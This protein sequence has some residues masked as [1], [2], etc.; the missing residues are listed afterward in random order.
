[1]ADERTGFTSLT[2][3]R[4]GPPDADAALADIRRIYFRTTKQTIQHDLAHAID[5]LKSLPTEEQRE[6]A[7]VYM[8][9]LAQMRSEWAGGNSG[10]SG[11]GG[12]SR[13]GSRK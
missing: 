2:S 3:L 6:R 12:R 9:G 10:N 4:K 8:D 7:A 5:L 13:K 1:V 11:K